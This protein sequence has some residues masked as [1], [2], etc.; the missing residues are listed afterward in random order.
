MLAY[1]PIWDVEVIEHSAG[2]YREGTRYLLSKTLDESWSLSGG[3][4]EESFASVGIRP[5]YHSLRFAGC[6]V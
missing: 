3:F 4:G 6:I 5:R 2:L 1:F